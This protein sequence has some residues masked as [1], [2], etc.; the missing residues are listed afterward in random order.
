MDMITEFRGEHWFLSNMSSSRQKVGGLQFSSAE[1]AFQACKVE[2]ILDRAKFMYMDGWEARKAGRKIT[3]RPH[4]N[5]M[6]L[7]MME[8]VI[9]SKFMGSKQLAQELVKTRGQYIKHENTWNDTYWGTVNGMGE[10]N[11][12]LILMSIR[13]ELCEWKDNK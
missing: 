6:R 13:N 3:L 4:W 5:E 9:R 12:G 1:A 8:L 10:N 11:L 2:N 7:D